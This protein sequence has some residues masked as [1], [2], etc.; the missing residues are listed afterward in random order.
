M[1]KS[2]MISSETAAIDCW[3]F[4]HRLSRYRISMD[5]TELLPGTLEMLL[6][7]T[8]SRGANHGYGIAQT[9]GRRRRMR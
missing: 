9:S 1:P 2:S 8:P 7:K 5:S 6:L 3:Y 4:R